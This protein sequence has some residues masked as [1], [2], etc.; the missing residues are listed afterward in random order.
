MLTI[1]FIRHTSLKISGDI[2]YGQTDIEVADTFDKE[3]ERVKQQLHEKRYDAIFTSPLSRASLLCEFCGYGDRAI[4]DP[5]IMERNFG[6]WELSVWS[7]VEEM[8]A[9]HPE[10]EQYFDHYGQV[11][12][13]GGETI[14]DLFERVADFIDEVRMER[15]NRVAVFCHG[16]VINSARWLRGEMDIDRLF[17]DVP[18]YG[19]V[20]PL[21]YAHLETRTVTLK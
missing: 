13:P 3:A 10:R 8:L 14:S 5:R 21:Q 9:T 11:I 1:D 19:S 4:K 17:I 16:G 6:I 2:C 15:Y 20:N 18:D 7:E 12:P